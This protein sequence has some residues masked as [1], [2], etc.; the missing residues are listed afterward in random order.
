LDR[1]I[2]RLSIPNTVAE[3]LQQRILSGE[4][5]EGDAL[6]QE[7]L[8]LEYD[9]SRMPIREALR[10]L[11]ATGLVAME[12]HKGAVVRA[13]PLAQ[14]AEL[15]ELR[16]LLEGDILAHAA[17][18]I[19]DAQLDAAEAILKALEQAYEAGEVG[20]W[21][22]LNWEFHRSLYLAGERVQSLAL[23]QT[24]NLQT[25]RYVRLHLLLTHGIE[26]A[27]TEHR[28]LIR[29]SRARD[30][31]AAVALLR[32]HILETGANLMRV[33]TNARRPDAP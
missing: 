14:I 7:A 16:A 24:V 10:Q 5:K 28:E 21:G 1:R 32:Q 17:P 25:D 27:E 18:K 13:L 23:A 19:T 15:F 12:M 29:L 31:D 2:K 30:V 33:I 26:N 20:R 11:E 3:S 6:V 4:F 22:E 8:A 9:V